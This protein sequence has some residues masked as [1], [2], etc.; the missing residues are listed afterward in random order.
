MPLAFHDAG[1]DG[2]GKRV[3]AAALPKQHLGM[4][5]YLALGSPQRTGDL[6]FGPDPEGPST[7]VPEDAPLL[8]PPVETEDLEELLAAAEAVEMGRPID[9][10]L[11]LLFRSSADVGGA[12][13]KARLRH[14]GAEWIAK[15]PAWGDS[16][17]A[18]RLEAVCLDLA[19]FAGVDVPEHQLHTLGPRTALLVRR[20][21][22]APGGGRR[23]YLSAA[24]L[25]KHP[26]AAHHT[27][28]TYV[29]V[30]V[31]ARAIGV[32]APEEQVY[33]R[34]LVNA[35]VH[36]TDDHL[37]NMGFVGDEGCWS[38]SPA[39][40]IVPHKNG[41]HVC[42]PAPGVSPARD[43]RVAAKA[44]RAFG[45]DAR[46]A[47]DIYDEVVAGVR[48]VNEALN[49]RGVTV[50]DRG[51]VMPLLAACLDPPSWE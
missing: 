51:T 46:R 27:T 1:P 6:V 32:P 37:R 22:R 12:R 34:L 21:D 4:A 41:R 49:V 36:N 35:F 28:R 14:D 44:F 2:W 5:E 19:E 16:F 8:A 50:K 3:L 31:V 30:A 17:D 38:L 25:L 29:D 26:V 43:P 13:P 47:R 39:F 9:R 11:R 24:T 20:F 40:D 15:F 23:G 18:P 7:W 10:H 33:R 48:R 45:L 42:A